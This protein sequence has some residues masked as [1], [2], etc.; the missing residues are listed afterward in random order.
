MAG[1]LKRTPEQQVA[2]DP[3]RHVWVAASA[4]TGK[5]HVL[6]DRM[7][8]LMLAGTAPDRILALTFTRAAAAEMQ[9]R[10]VRRL[11]EWLALDDAGLSAELD[12]LG[13]A[14]SAA[15]LE[16]ARGL[17]ARALDVPGGLK[18]QTLHAF[19]QG[20]LAGF[21]LEAGLTPGFTALDERDARALRRR[22][23]VECIAE[24]S[25][26]GDDHFLADLGQLS[27]LKGEAGL[28]QS[29]D[30]LIQHSDALL[31]FRD[32][33]GPGAAVRAWLDVAER[34]MPGERLAAAL[35]P[36]TFDEGPARRFADL[37]DEWATPGARANAVK[38]RDWIGSGRE[39]RLAGFAGACETVFRADQSI[40][41]F[42]TGEKK[43]PGLAAAAAD[44]ASQLREF[45][46]FD[47]RV[48]AAE[49]AARVLRA[50][51]RVVD[52]YRRLKRAAVAI[53]YDDMIART[54]ELLGPPG[55]SN[56]VGWKLDSRF[57]H[58]LVDEAQDTNS[59]QWQIIGRLVE[60]YF[61]G[62][63]SARS[64]FVVGDHK[65]AIYGFQGTDP[66]VFERW[67]LQTTPLA[68]AGE[69]PLQVVD[70]ALSFRSGPAVL[71][72][73]NG[74]LSAAGGPA[75]GMAQPPPPHVPNRA[76]APGEV[77]LWPVVTPVPAPTGS[78]D[79]GIVVDGDA[80]AADIDDS[81]ESGSEAADYEMA[82]RLAVQIA[83][84]LTPGHDERLWLPA[85]GRWAVP[86]DILILLRKRSALM[87]ALV[88][89]LHEQ[90]V[91]VAGVD[92]LL[93]TEPLAVMDLLA[94]VRF[95][96]QPEDDLNLACLLVSPFI[97]WSHEDIRRIGG[98][99]PD[100]WAALGRAADDD[101]AND[102]RGWLGQV[103]ALADRV[104]PYEFLDTILS[105]PLKGR[106]KLVARLG[107]QANDPIDE[108][109]QQAQ[110]YALRN[111]PAL[112]GFLAWVEAEGSDVKRD[113][114][115]S[116]GQVRLMT[117]HGSKGLEAPVVVLAD[118]ATQRRPHQAD[119]LPVEI[120]GVGVLPLFHP[121]KQELPEKVRAG[122]AA[123]DAIEAEEDLR[124]LY[125][126]L[127]RAADH[128]FIGG[129]IGASAHKKLGTDNDRCW[130][131]RIAPVLAGIE[132][133]EQVVSELWG[134]E[135]LRL[136]DGAWTAPTADTTTVA[137]EAAAHGLHDIE[138][139]IAPEPTR[140]TRPLTPS[141]A[142]EAPAEGPAA[143]ALRAAALRGT[144][145]HKLFERLPAV[146]PAE[147]R[148]QALQWLAAQGAGDAA[149]ALLAQVLSVLDDPAHASLFGE[150]S[151][152]EAPVAGLVGKQA[153]VG[154]VDRLAVLADRVLIVDFKTS[155]RVPP[156]AAE[157]PVAHRRQ[158][159][160][161]VEVLKRAFPGRQIEGMLLYTAGPVCH[162][163]GVAEMAGLLPLD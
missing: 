129:A 159:A 54:V 157:A 62:D 156:T 120:A 162:R 119:H 163:L 26:G 89:E 17:F 113:A 154:I 53:D 4:G 40:R 36:G 2:A 27:V 130:H 115:A 58:V 68:A 150:D 48:I 138:T 73:V 87:G 60:E 39:E 100:L 9:N 28:M 107:R 46:D 21:P 83:R 92:R 75:L 110:S 22:A 103:L 14:P 5:T 132:G 41:S 105:G 3:A 128:L 147:R 140:P 95:A 99:R 139:G 25:D 13:V 76:A 160:A 34:E 143:E 12:A 123:L 102:A 153:I 78:A 43:A 11:G 155:L 135:T 61:S 19:A 124:L 33:A 85:H 133:V 125:V 15:M 20:L 151:L 55:M 137:P 122:H 96:I 8:R 64:L 148:A 65:Q 101:A 161:Y 71:R 24:A 38:L 149:E 70:L 7:L 116:G 44:F 72:L 98:G 32:G 121:P 59:R 18:V 97:G 30:V 37:N 145:V 45:Q 10:I 144:L 111:P 86:G 67:R 117:I 136:R 29:I 57:D 131:T 141:A 109:L 114:E 42:A 79:G 146:A 77:V 81:T 66:R 56:Y 49:T 126:G 16:T 82:R 142:P 88:A 6:T 84:W 63:G 69:R 35:S 31:S 91:A 127:T 112:A 51:H 50:G 93:L 158:M 104:G 94:L 47:L 90:R 106:Q 152:A 80:A 74:F 118:S 52:R 134:G 1:P 23:L 108:L